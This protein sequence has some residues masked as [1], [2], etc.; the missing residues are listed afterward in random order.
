MVRRI[1]SNGLIISVVKLHGI[2]ELHF[3]R[4]ATFTAQYVLHGADIH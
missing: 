4:D 2:L 3:T 1:E